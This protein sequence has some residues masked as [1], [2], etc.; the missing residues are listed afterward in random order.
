MPLLLRKYWKGLI[1]G[2]SWCAGIYLAVLFL[3][4]T[5]HLIWRHRWPD[6]VE[7]NRKAQ[8]RALDDQMPS[9]AFL[10]KLQ[11]QPLDPSSRRRLKKWADYFDAQ[12]AFAFYPADSYSWQGYCF[13]QLGQPLNAI[14]AYQKAIQLNPPYFWFHHYLGTVYYANQQWEPAA[15]SLSDALKTNPYFTLSTMRNY[16]TVS[17]PLIFQ[18]RPYLSASDH[19]LRNNQLLR[20]GYVDCYQMLTV[21][22]F[23][24]GR[25]ADALEQSLAALQIQET[26]QNFFYVMAGM[27]AA[28]MNRYQEAL[29]LITQGLADYQQDPVVMEYFGRILQSLGRGEEARSVLSQAQQYKLRNLPD[30]F[31]SV[32]PSMILF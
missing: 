1:A 13:H 30:I 14:A 11:Q 12:V 22:L 32:D 26:D 20:E 24:L 10:A 16:I 4:L 19:M 27:A 25:Y 21:S 7:I 15:R 17:P 28:E 9:L 8:A 23:R 2:L 31:V 5:N 3:Y 29:A 18:R 6:L